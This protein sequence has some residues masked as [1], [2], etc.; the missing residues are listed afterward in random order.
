[1]RIRIIFLSFAVATISLMCLPQKLL[2]APTDSKGC[3]SKECH[4]N[5]TDNTNTHPTGLQCNDCHTPDTTSHP[6]PNTTDFTTNSSPCSGCHEE[7]ADHKYL[8]PPVAAADCLACHIV[9][10]EKRNNYINEQEINFCYNCHNTVVAVGETVLHGEIA[11]DKCS[12]CHTVHG[13]SFPSLLRANYS[14]DFTNDYNAE[15]YRLCFRC[16]RIDLL[17]HPRT[18]YNTKFRDSKKNLHYLHVNI[19]TKGRSCSSCHKTHASRLPHLMAETVLFGSWQLPLNFQATENG[20]KCSPGCH[21]PE[22]YDRR[23]SR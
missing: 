14:L 10:G 13:S 9:H 2:C 21:M 19:K 12:S 20:G 11:Q 15:E 5:M 23:L 4:S 22:S 6:D 1:M 8:H 17:L 16:H 3:T 7:V 18:S